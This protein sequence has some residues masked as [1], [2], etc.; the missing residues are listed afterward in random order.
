M[1]YYFLTIDK[2]KTSDGIIPTVLTYKEVFEKLK[3]SCGI[4]KAD[5][6]YPV[7]C[8][9][10]KTKVVCKL[11]CNKWLHY[12]GIVKSFHKIERKDTKVKNFS[13]HLKIINDLQMMCTYSGYINKNKKDGCD[14]SVVASLRI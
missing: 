7:E 1:L 12:H 11:K 3:R 6:L 9:E 8:Y 4:I 10:Y 14:I 5:T 2:C 13:V